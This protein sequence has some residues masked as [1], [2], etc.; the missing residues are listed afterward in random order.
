MNSLFD[1]QRIMRFYR[2]MHLVCVNAHPELAG[3]L[4]DIA[5]KMKEIFG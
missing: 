1:L 5:A 4:R 3:Q 2:N